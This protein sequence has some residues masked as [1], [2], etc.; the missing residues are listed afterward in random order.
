LFSRFGKS[1]QS[2]CCYLAR[3]RCDTRAVGIHPPTWPN[4]SKT[5][6]SYS[7]AETKV[8]C[9][10]WYNPSGLLAI[11]EKFH[12]IER[13]CDLRPDRLPAFKLNYCSASAFLTGLPST[14]ALGIGF[15]FFGIEGVNFRLLRF[16]QDYEPPA[17]GQCFMLDFADQPAGLIERI[18]SFNFRPGGPQ[19]IGLDEKKGS[20]VNF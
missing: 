16:L 6:F 4:N 8:Y 12:A 9:Q 17:G 20:S 5:I 3:P 18:L 15:G 19:S 14:V 10:D 13:L 7:I 11:P 2:A 1:N